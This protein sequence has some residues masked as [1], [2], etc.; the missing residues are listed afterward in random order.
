MIQYVWRQIFIKIKF[1]VVKKIL[2]CFHR[3]VSDGGTTSMTKVNQNGSL[4]LGMET[5]KPGRTS[6]LKVTIDKR[7]SN[8]F[9]YVLFIIA[10]S[11]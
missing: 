2:I 3:S 6:S 1:L 9:C 5:F 4:R 11:G 7:L 10:I 8:R